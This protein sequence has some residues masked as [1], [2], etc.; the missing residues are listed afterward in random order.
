M[1]IRII[2]TQVFL[3]NTIISF[4]QFGYG[5]KGGISLSNSLFTVAQ[6]SLPDFFDSR[7][8]GPG[9]YFGFYGQIKFSDKMMLSPELL[10]TQKGWNY[11]MSLVHLNYLEIPVLIS[12]RPIKSIGIEAGPNIS[13]LLS[14]NGSFKSFYSGYDY[15]LN[16]GVVYSI[17]KRFSVGVRYYLGLK[18][19]NEVYFVDP[20]NNPLGHIKERN[21][22]LQIGVT[23][24]L[25]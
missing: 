13:L 8:I 18:V 21:S 12:F 14:S 10:F 2:L 7:T 20:N 4:C 9:V 3:L 15:G 24:Q 25:K 22:S 23:Y 17:L 11:R 19:V 5:A 1:R 16:A 6:G